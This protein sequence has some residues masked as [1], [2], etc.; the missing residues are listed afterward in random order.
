MNNGQET[1]CAMCGR[2]W[3]KLIA[4]RKKEQ[5]TKAEQA[6]W[7]VPT[8]PMWTP[9][10]GGGNQ[11]TPAGLGKVSSALSDV[12]Q[13]LPEATQKALTK[14][15][16][17]VPK[18]S[19]PPGL[20]VPSA[21]KGSM[22]QQ[23]YH[24][25]RMVVYS[26]AGDHV[27]KLLAAA[28]IPP[29]EDVMLDE[30]ESTPGQRLTRVVTDFRKSTNQMQKLVKKRAMLQEKADHLKEELEA[31]M[32]DVAQVGREIEVKDAEMKDT[33]REFKALTEDKATTAYDQMEQVLAEAGHDL[34]EG[35]KAKLKAAL[36]TKTAEEEIGPDPFLG[37]F[38]SRESFPQE[39][40]GIVPGAT[41]WPA[42]YGPAR[43]TPAIARSTP[44]NPPSRKEEVGD[45]PPE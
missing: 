11:G 2:K 38:D 22:T 37:R 19:P 42:T 18:P 23:E 7:H 41:V 25:A 33:A 13:D 32:L 27:Q 12:W 44:L 29:P 5:E 39:L 31:L 14:A 30:P 20:R 21:L 9:P 16:C 36:L 35:T 17:K 43:G 26:G 6:S 24:A 40:A 28:G 34:A 10:K 15:G 1:H 45:S 8:W 4:Q 3:A